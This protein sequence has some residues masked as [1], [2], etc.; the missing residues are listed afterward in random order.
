[1]TLS[2]ISNRGCGD[3]ISISLMF[4]LRN[5]ASLMLYNTWHAYFFTCHTNVGNCLINLTVSVVITDIPTR[6]I[7]RLKVFYTIYLFICLC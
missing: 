7:L 3:N 1:M 2:K 6:L 5:F 4:L